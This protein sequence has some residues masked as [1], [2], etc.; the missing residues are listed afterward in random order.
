MEYGLYCICIYG[1]HSAVRHSC[2]SALYVAFNVGA[3]WTAHGRCSSVT[4]KPPHT[5]RLPSRECVQKGRIHKPPLGPSLALSPP[6]LNPTYSTVCLCLCE[7]EP[8]PH[9]FSSRQN[10]LICR[11]PSPFLAALR[12]YKHA[13]HLSQQFAYY[14]NCYCASVHLYVYMYLHFGHNDFEMSSSRHR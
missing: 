5:D 1:L 10:A 3:Y 4:V 13:T 12:Y 7:R 14:N 8:L 11:S 9:L 6:A 2:E